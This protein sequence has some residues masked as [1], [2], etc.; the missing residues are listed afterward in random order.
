LIN[1]LI[2]CHSHGQTLLFGG[3]QHD[4]LLLLLL[5]LQ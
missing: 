1:Y 3:I 5:G 2:L 4:L